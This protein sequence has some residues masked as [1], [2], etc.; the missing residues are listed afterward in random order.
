MGNVYSAQNFAAH[1]IY[2]LNDAN[3]FVNETEIQHLLA[4]VDV[5]WQ[6]VFG[7][8]AYREA[9]ANFAEGYYVKEVFDAY[10]EL[11]EARVTEPAKEWH[12]P[13]GEFQLI[14]RPYGVPAFT[15]VEERIVNHV[16]RR[17]QNVSARIAV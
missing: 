4:D 10:K 15:A 11:G 5:M 1:F 6:K 7:R 16:L 2:E 8:S 14:L 13:Y 12:L 17:Y 3:I 9:T